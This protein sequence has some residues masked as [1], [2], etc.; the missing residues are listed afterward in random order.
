[1]P[2][3]IGP[4][5]YIQWLSHVALT[6]AGPKLLAGFMDAPVKGIPTKWSAITVSP[7][8]IGASLPSP[9]GSTAVAKITKTSAKVNMISVPIPCKAV[10]LDPSP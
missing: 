5:Q 10:T 4:I 7:M 1:M 3:T 6:S 9:F 8:S 2:P